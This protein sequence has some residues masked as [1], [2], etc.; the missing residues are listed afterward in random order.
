MREYSGLPRRTPPL[1]LRD[2][3][4]NDEQK[5][6]TQRDTAARR[7]RLCEHVLQRLAEKHVWQSSIFE[8]NLYTKN[9]IF[10]EITTILCY[11]RLWPSGEVANTTVCKTVTRR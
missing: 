7:S 5:S 11:S 1:V 10:N 8:Q 9:S 3:P 6:N 2:A 4:R